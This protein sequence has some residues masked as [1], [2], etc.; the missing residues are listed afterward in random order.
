MKENNIIS[1][2]RNQGGDAPLSETD[3][4]PSVEE[5]FKEIRPRLEYL[6]DAL[7]SIDL[8]SGCG[9]LTKGFSMTGIRSILGSDI[10]ENCEKTFTRNFPDTPF[11]CKD[12][13][14]IEKPEVDALLK[15]AFGATV[16]GC[17]HKADAGRRNHL[18]IPRK[19]ATCRH[20]QTRMCEALMG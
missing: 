19:V 10:D 9:G 15:G 8:F 12:I 11:L 13:T 16:V 6:D 7:T 20:Q 17:P 14:D 18:A 1:T 3:G 4:L 5:V 2:K